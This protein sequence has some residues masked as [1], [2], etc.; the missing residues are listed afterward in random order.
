MVMVA[1]VAHQACRGSTNDPTHS[2]TPPAHILTKQN[3]KKAR[4]A[5]EM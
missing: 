3:K 4:T 1:A 2:Q 5:S